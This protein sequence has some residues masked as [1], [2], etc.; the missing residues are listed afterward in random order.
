MSRIVCLID[1][2]NLYHSLHSV[3]KY[4]VYKW[5]DLVS[6]VKKF[7]ANKD[8]INGIFYFTALATWSQEKVRKHKLY[9]RAQELNGVEIVYGEFRRKDKQCRICKKLFQTFEEKQTDVNIAVKLMELTIKD[10]Y[11]KAIIF[12]GDSDMVPV[13]TTVRKLYPA[14]KIGIVIPIGGR[15]EILKQSADFYMKMKEIHLK[16]SLLPDS[17]NIG[18]GLTINCPAEW[19]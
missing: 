17:V 2:F 6:F 18:G 14:K 3:K 13:I 10:T 8:S 19:K 4:H 11:D 15:A 5:L 7:I 12:T 1:G 9:I 16:T